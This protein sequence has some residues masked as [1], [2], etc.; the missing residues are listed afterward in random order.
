MRRTVL[1]CAVLVAAFSGSAAS[2]V[3]GPSPPAGEAQY[4]AFQIFTGSGDTKVPIGGQPVLREM[5][6][7]KDLDATARNIVAR[8]GTTGDE[9]HKLALIFGPISFDHSDA[10]VAAFVRSAFD[11]ALAH[12]VA[13]GF[14]LDDSIYWG[15]RRDLM[16][17]AR[18]VE[19]SAFDGPLSTGRRLD[20]GPTP[21]KAPP[22][23]CINAPAI[24]AEVRRRGTEVIGHAIRTGLDRLARA[25]HGELFA[26]VI[27]GWET[28]IGND[29]DGRTLGYCA[30]ANRGIKPGAPIAAIDRARVDAVAHFISLWSDAVVAAGVPATRIYAHIAFAAQLYQRSAVTVGGTTFIQR[31]NFAPSEVAF[32]ANRRAGFSTYPQAGI[33]DAIDAV[34]RG[35][36]RAPWASAEGSNVAMGGLG[37][38]SSGMSDETYLARMFNHGAAVVNIFG[39]GVGSA[40]NGFREA[41]ERPQAIAA[42]TKFLRDEA[43]NEGPTATTVVDR[44]PKKIGRIRD[45]LPAWMQ[46]SG[47][48]AQVES[49]MQQLDAALKAGDLT[50]AEGLADKVLARIAGG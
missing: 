50:R 43:L 44:L 15:A 30:A 35:H 45:T 7:A 37:P 49:L 12:N 34:V 23:M 48:D 42:Y 17:D 38:L 21:D 14:H 10:Q 18:N 28:M 24:E 29:I 33:Y 9:R 26:G 13:I 47:G 31:I 25:K 22:Q 8:L 20:W 46:K 5:P 16:S 11:I 41:A 4:L 3:I 27:V 39:W 32:G 19:R 1:T 36:G 40:D 6:S 2:D